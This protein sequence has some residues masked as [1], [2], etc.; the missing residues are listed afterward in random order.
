MKNQ[1]ETNEYKK[2]NE[3]MES[4]VLRSPVKKLEI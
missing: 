2:V 4:N 3:K 1:N